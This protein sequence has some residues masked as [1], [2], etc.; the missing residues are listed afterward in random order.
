MTGGASIVLRPTV[1]IDRGL[2]QVVDM[3]KV[4]FAQGSREVVHRIIPSAL[5][6]GALMGVG[7]GSPHSGEDRIEGP[8]EGD[9]MSG[10]LDEG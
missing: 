8:V 5:L 7:R 2:E 1:A 3:F 4:A 6:A 10:V 9:V